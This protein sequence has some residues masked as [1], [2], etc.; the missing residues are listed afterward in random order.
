MNQK[1]LLVFVLTLAIIIS[2]RWSL[3]HA[4]T[5]IVDNEEV[6]INIA[7][8]SNKKILSYIEL[9]PKDSPY[10]VKNLKN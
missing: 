7:K 4:E 9:S 6:K 1:N 8:R 5:I 2:N 3:V 10:L